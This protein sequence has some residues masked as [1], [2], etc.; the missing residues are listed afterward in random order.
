MHIDL[1]MQEGNRCLRYSRC[2]DHIVDMSTAECSRGSP[3]T[4]LIRRHKLSEISIV[5]KYPGH[6]RPI[7]DATRSGRI[8]P[9]IPADPPESLPF[10]DQL[11]ASPLRPLP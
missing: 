10:I 11:T 5:D 8:D 2:L 4:S 1:A 7:L 9:L 6:R 3:H